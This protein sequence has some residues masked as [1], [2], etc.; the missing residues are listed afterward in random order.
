MGK[1][2]T[3]VRRFID[4]LGRPDL[5]RVGAIITLAILALVVLGLVCSVCAAAFWRTTRDSPLA[6]DHEE[7]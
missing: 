7:H 5:F 3:R 2:F 6:P 4:S 1:A